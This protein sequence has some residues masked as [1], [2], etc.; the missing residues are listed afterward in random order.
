M[1]KVAQIIEYKRAWSQS[2]SLLL[3]TAQGEV[4]DL[5]TPMPFESEPSAPN[6]GQVY[7][8]IKNA[9]NAVTTRKKAGVYTTFFEVTLE[10]GHVRCYTKPAEKERELFFEIGPIVPTN[11]TT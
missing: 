10:R 7:E 5:N 3:A 1:K 9:A 4:A 8:T 2:A 11:A 6:W